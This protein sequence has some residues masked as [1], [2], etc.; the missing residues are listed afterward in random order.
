MATIPFKL[1]FPLVARRRASELMAKRDDGN[2]IAAAII[3]K[4]DMQLD[5]EI[6]YNFCCNFLLMMTLEFASADIDIEE[7]EGAEGKED[8][9][10]GGEAQYSDVLFLERQSEEVD[11]FVLMLLRAEEELTI[12][13]RSTNIDLQRLLII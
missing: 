3:D 11:A 9:V 2:V 7:D 1:S 6:I 12:I 8:G 13:K 5:A 10:E 4:Y